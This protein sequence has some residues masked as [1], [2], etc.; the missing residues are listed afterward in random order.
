MKDLIRLHRLDGE[1][2]F[3]IYLASVGKKVPLRGG[4]RTP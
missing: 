2:E 3:V 1:E 4:K